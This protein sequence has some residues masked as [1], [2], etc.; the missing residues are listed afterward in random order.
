MV[1]ISKTPLQI[2]F[3]MSDLLP[4]ISRTLYFEGRKQYCVAFNTGPRHRQSS[5]TSTEGGRVGKREG[6]KKEGREG[7][8]EANLV[9]PNPNFFRLHIFLSAKHVPNKECSCALQ[10]LSDE[11]VRYCLSPFYK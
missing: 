1:H 8:K 6:I 3:Y 7:E 9:T 5:K 11:G 4:P 10:V 2:S